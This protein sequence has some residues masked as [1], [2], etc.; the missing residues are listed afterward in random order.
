MGLKTKG[1]NDRAD[2]AADEGVKNHSDEICK[3]S[4]LQAKRQQGYI[5]FMKSIHDHILEAFYKRKYIE[6]VEINETGKDEQ[7]KVGKPTSKHVKIGEIPY[8]REVGQIDG[9]NSRG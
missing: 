9:R 2:R 6:S 5:W 4:R 1:G 7:H 8:S 3:I